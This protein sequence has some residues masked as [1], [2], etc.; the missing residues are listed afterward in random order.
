[1]SERFVASDPEDPH[2]DQPIVTGGAP[3]MAADVAV[4]L[5]HGRGATAKGMVA[6]A[7]DFYR[8]GVTF[9]A[10]QAAHQNWYPASFDAPREANEPALTSAVDRVGA[11]LDRAADVGIPPAR[12]VILGFSQGACVAAEFVRRHPRRYGGVVVLAGA[13]PGEETPDPGEQSLDGTPV[14]LGCADDDPHVPVE[15]VHESARVLEAMD[16]DVTEEIYADAGHSITGGE[17]EAVQSLLADLLD[18][19]NE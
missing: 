11:A 7:D 8:H 14:F 4:V 19:E 2:A 15:R 9:L 12:T 16:G 3:A 5:L 13:L 18:G 6:S 17:V 10:P 1:M